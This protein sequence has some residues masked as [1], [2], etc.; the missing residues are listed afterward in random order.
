MHGT[1]CSQCVTAPVAELTD[2]ACI[3][4]TDDSTFSNARPVELAG[5]DLR[6]THWRLDLLTSKGSN[7][8][9]P[10]TASGHQSPRGLSSHSGEIMLA[11]LVQADCT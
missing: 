10:D 6:A 2:V 9:A 11:R 1:C 3:E 4:F 8:A 7:T 5:A